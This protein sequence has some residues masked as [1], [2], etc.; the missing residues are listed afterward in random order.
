MA[1]NLE[2]LARARQLNAEPP[3]RAEIANLLADARAQLGDARNAGLNAS[4]RFALAYNA[5]HAL[6]LA[7][8]RANG[9]RPSSAGHRRIL[10][11]ALDAT[12]NAP[13]DLWMALD[14]YHDRRNRMTYEGAAAAGDVEA[15]DLTKLAGELEPLVAKTV[16][17]KG[18]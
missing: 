1:S 10:F 16:K 6:A 4:S 5:A 9:Y 15:R 17:A 13:R 8:L 14:R 3:D 18:F 12:C 7:A 11:Q 2:N